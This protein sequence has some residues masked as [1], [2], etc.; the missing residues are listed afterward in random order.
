MKRV[1]IVHGWGGNPQNNW[2][3]WLK[4]ELTKRGFEV[5]VP[6]L[7]DTDNPR[8]QNWVPALS[9]VVGKADQNTYLVSHSLGCQVIA[10]YIEGLP[11]NTEIGG[12]VFVA[13]FFKTL[14]G[15]DEED[16]ETEKHWLDAPIDLRAVKKH[17]I[18][19]VAI[20]SDNDPFVP[21]ENQDDF[22]DALGS[23]VIIEHAM[24]HFNDA[25]GTKELPIV[26]QKILELGA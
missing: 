21:L 12:V 2:F 26:L 11:E 13:G 25:G 8:M 16:R 24:G 7:P 14:T 17:L 6:Q 10:R 18:H 19:S 1:I 15:L 9:D 20:F 5:L 4:N 23:E 22:R 3:P